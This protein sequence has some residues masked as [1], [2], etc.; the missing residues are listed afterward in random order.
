MAHPRSLPVQ[1]VLPILLG[2][3]DDHGV[4]VLIGANLPL[5]LPCATLIRLTRLPTRPPRGRGSP[6]SRGRAP[7]RRGFEPGYFTPRCQQRGRAPARD[8]DASR[9]LRARDRRPPG[10]RRPRR[11]TQKRW[12]AGCGVLWAR[13]HVA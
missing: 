10:P 12:G 7:C 4:V 8:A 13:R 11:A 3:G 6:G 9:P 2:I 1:L 5:T